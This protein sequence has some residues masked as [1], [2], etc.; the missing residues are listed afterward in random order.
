LTPEQHKAWVKAERP[1]WTKFE[2]QIGKD[3]IDAAVKSNEPSTN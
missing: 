3:I 2:K 1:V